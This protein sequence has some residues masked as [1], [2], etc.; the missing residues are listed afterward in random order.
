[1][2]HVVIPVKAKLLR[3]I[4]GPVLQNILLICTSLTLLPPC[5]LLSST[6]LVP[7]CHIKVCLSP[8]AFSFLASGLLHM[9]FPQSWP[10]CLFSCS[11][12]WLNPISLWVSVWFGP[13]LHKACPGTPALGF[14]LLRCWPM[15][16]YFPAGSISTLHCFSP[17]TFPSQWIIRSYSLLSPSL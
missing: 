14:M 1:M 3:C 11:S 9:L 7:S 16:H 5:F 15:S 4:V 13:C 12:T 6:I 2:V 8:V 10:L 17:W